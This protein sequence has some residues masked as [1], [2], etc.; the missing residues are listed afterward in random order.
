MFTGCRAGEVFTLQWKD[1]HLEDGHLYLKDSKVGVRTI[2]LN[3]KAKQILT[4][5]Q[6]QESLK[7]INRNT[8]GQNLF[9]LEPALASLWGSE[10]WELR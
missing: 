4:S 9:Y 2:A 5:L 6:K 3:D 7:L 10:L 1:V 8:P